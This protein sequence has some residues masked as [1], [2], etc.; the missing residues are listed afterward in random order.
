MLF[1]KLV[2]SSCS[3]DLVSSRRIRPLCLMTGGWPTVMIRSLALSWMTVAS[4][5]S[6]RTLLIGTEFL[7]TN[8]EPSRGRL[9][10]GSGRTLESLP[11]NVEARRRGVRR[12]ASDPRRDQ[13]GL[14]LL[15]R[16]Y[17]HHLRR[18]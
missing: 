2:V 13:D 7:V 12:D 3:S 8:Y 15:T 1:I 16:N 4:S 11:L 10:R 18:I 14:A 9:R 17:P 5:F 6:I